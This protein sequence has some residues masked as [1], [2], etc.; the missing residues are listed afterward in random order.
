MYGEWKRENSEKTKE[1]QQTK[2]MY[3]EQF[4]IAVYTNI[5]KLDVSFLI[6]CY[7]LNKFAIIA[8][9]LVKENLVILHFSKWK[10][11]YKKKKNKERQS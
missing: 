8:V 5:E 3:T 2:N 1:H 10:T 6:V 7:K 9:I 11:F 4:C